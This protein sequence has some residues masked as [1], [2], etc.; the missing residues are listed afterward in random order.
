MAQQDGTKHTTRPA[1]L[2]KD[3]ATPPGG[4]APSR[5]SL[6]LAAGSAGAGTLGAMGTAA[7]VLAQSLT[8]DRVVPRGAAPAP[9]GA[10]T[11]ADVLFDTLE[12]WGVEVVF[13]LPGDGIGAVVDALR[14]RQDRIRFVQVRHEESAAFMAAGYAKMTGRLG[15]CL[16]TTGPGAIHL[17]N[18]LYD[19]KMD[20]AP[21]LAITGQ[22]DSDL[23][24][25]GYPQEV[26]QARAFADVALFNELVLGPGH[27]LKMAHLA[28]RA[29]LSGP[30]VAHLFVPIDVQRQ[31][32][33]GYTPSRNDAGSRVGQSWTAPRPVPPAGQLRQ[34]ADL[35][36]AG[37]RVAILA[38]QGCLG[39]SAELE[40]VADRLGAPVAK[41]L[42]GKMLLPDHHP[43]TTRTVGH[44]GTTAS[45]AAMDGCDT[46]LIVGSTMPWLQFYPKP[47]QART[48]QV[49]TDPARIGLRTPVE[50][51]LAGDSKA[52]LGALLPML[53]RKADRSFHAGV[54]EEKKR[55]EATLAAMEASTAS[56][57]LPQVVLGHLNRLLAD[58][59]VVTM[60]A[61]GNV[62]FAARHL[63]MRGTQ[64]YHL[65]GTHNTMAPALPYAIAGQVAFPGRQVVAV[66]GDGGFTMLMGEFATAAKYGLPITAV[67]LRNDAYGVV[68]WEQQ[69]AGFPVFGTELQPIDFV[70]V[71][72][73]CG[74]VGWR[75][76]RPEQVE[77]ALRQALASKRPALVEAVVANPNP[78]EPGKYK[79]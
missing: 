78:A 48:V 52:T 54:I 16:A 31:P 1:S 74:G 18:G 2:D 53:E 13:G 45:V 32:L 50:V 30:G 37:R 6:L 77:G 9:D 41:A 60:D 69:E 26:D 28:C 58:D 10:S 63:L 34:A 51:G 25:T 56:P 19:A 49:D 71:A 12:G 46:L 14:R 11:T 33:S 27:M 22:T 65:A 3:G 15:V 7:P 5:R 8:T 35:L 38:G 24:G 76:D 29:A 70:R 44:L 73:A 4:A 75:V 64:R 61:G 23:I 55:W 40:A 66:A 21:V 36:N 20:R 47:G 42:L 39:A 17:L 57:M 43:L 68:G 59:A 79:A 62:V 72:E 67:V